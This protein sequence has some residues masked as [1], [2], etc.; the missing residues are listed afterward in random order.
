VIVVSML[1]L[2]FA[3]WRKEDN[4]S[5]CDATD[6]AEADTNDKETSERRRNNGSVWIDIDVSINV[7]VGGNQRGEQEQLRTRAGRRT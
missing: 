5:S 4:D 2:P 7:K 1:V 3:P 6:D